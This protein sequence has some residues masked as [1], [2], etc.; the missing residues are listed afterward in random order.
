MKFIV[1]ECLAVF[2][3]SF[4]ECPEGGIDLGNNGPNASLVHRISIPELTERLQHFARTQP[5]PLFDACLPHS[6]AISLNK[7]SEVSPEM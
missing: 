1:T 2:S 5:S 3:G 7:W 4:I 6:N